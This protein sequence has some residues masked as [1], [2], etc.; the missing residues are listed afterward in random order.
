MMDV[1][2]IVRQLVPL[3]GG[4]DNIHSAIHCATRL[5]VVLEDDTLLD[6]NAIDEIKGVKASFR[7]SGQVQVAFSSSV[8]NDVYDEFINYTQIN[9]VSNKESASRESKKNLGYFKR[10]ANT[11][12][13]IF[14]P[15]IPA[16]IASGLL[17]GLLSLIKNYG[18]LDIH[19]PIYIL[20][21][22]FSSAAFIILPV[23]IGFNAAKVFGGNPYIGA[24][25]GGVLVHPS[26]ANIWG[27]LGHYQTLDL[28]GFQVAMIGYQGTVFPILLT[29]WFM[30]YL[31]KFL[32]RLV[33]E[34]VEVIFVP[35]ITLII[36]GFVSILLIGPAGRMLGDG[37]AFSLTTLIDHTGWFAGMLFGGLYSV[38]AMT[39]IQNS[40]HAI[41]AGLLSN[42]KIGVNYLL[43]IWSMANV[44]Q[45]GACLAVWFRTRNE[46]V[47][48]I[49]IPATFSAMIGSVEAAVFGVN[50]R[51]VK[52]FVAGMLGGAAGGAWV[53][54]NKVYAT[55]VG[56][57][58][59]P[60]LAIIQASSLINQII[61]L[62][63][64][65]GIA[66]SI[67]LIFKYDKES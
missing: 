65:F 11:L 53:V 13:K 54:F 15:L 66:F 24:T 51:Y 16:I 6:L 39:G 8:I 7:K 36:S 3:L 56:L 42:P 12:S 34:A 43:P 10:I 47:R 4:K 2:T 31:E 37:I 41:E 59:L 49:A 32:K 19:H 30:S 20:L 5:R 14:I 29:V 35:V 50:L 27:G 45:G 21:G 25:L 33:P 44:A 40:F 60:G 46:K 64:S 67:S 17:M 58:G 22:V 57:T 1:K 52:P 23:L 62:A 18:W 26:L 38:I 48:K 55:G 28:Y 61:G 63:I 9:E